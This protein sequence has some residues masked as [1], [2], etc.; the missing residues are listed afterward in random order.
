[1]AKRFPSGKHWPI[2]F[3]EQRLNTPRSLL[4]STSAIMP[5]DK[6]EKKE[7]KEKKVKEVTI[8][9]AEDDVEMADVDESQVRPCLFFRSPIAMDSLCHCVVT[10]KIQE[11]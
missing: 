8:E 6:S 2:S 7:K 5:K 3:R 11:G 4:S 9:E 10:Q 1:M